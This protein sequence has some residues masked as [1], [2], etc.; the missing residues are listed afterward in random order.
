MDF[1]KNCSGAIAYVKYSSNER[2]MHYDHKLERPN[3]INGNA[4]LYCRNAVAEPMNAY[5]TTKIIAGI[6]WRCE[7]CGETYS[8]GRHVCKPEAER[9]R[10]NAETIAA[11]MQTCNICGELWKD[12]HICATD[13]AIVSVSASNQSGC[14]LCYYSDGSGAAI[15]AAS[16]EIT[17]LRHAVENRMLIRF[18]AWGEVPRI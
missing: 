1:C 8:S 5:Y 17:A 13:A 10:E 18:Q 7:L 6:T 11:S 3:G 15:F 2:W 12:R 14:W 9:I 16:D 4:W